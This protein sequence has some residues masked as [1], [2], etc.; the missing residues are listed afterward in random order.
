MYKLGI[1]TFEGI[2]G[3]SA[4]DSTMEANYVQHALIENK[5]RLQRVGTNLEEINATI[6]L[7]AAF[8]VPE[9]EMATLY[10]MLEG[11]ETQPLTNGAGDYFGKYV[12]TSIQLTTQKSYA[13]GRLL[14][15]EAA[16]RLLEAL[17]PDDAIANRSEAFAIGTGIEGERQFEIDTEFSD[18]G[19]ATALL[20]EFNTES[21]AVDN[22]VAQTIVDEDTADAN[23][24]AASRR[25][26][27]VGVALDKLDT[28]VNNTQSRIYDAAAQIRSNLSVVTAA[29]AVLKNACDTVDVVAVDASND[30]YQQTVRQFRRY[31]S[32]I[33][34]LRAIRD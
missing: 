29:L 1:V 33:A 13:N 26:A 30:T 4:F 8:C 17:N 20:E 10:A 19:I 12:V 3:F 31:S 16:I 9:N 34:I 25:L 24:G 6:R 2:K 14:E 21:E 18:A 27:N 22:L 11:S 28:L 7:H 5:P 32:P 15:C 23:L